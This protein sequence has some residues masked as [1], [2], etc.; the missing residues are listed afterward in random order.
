MKR[1]T[2]YSNSRLFTEL[3]TADSGILWIIREMVQK[4]DKNEHENC[5]DQFI[6]TI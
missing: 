6:F 3:A 4:R 2:K 5:F 1:V